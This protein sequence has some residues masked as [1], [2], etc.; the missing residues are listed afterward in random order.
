MFS[1]L[2]SFV[3]EYLK[4]KSAWNPMAVPAVTYHVAIPFCSAAD[5]LPGAEVEGGWDQTAPAAGG[6]PGQGQVPALTTRDIFTTVSRPCWRR[7]GGHRCGENFLK[8]LF[9]AMGNCM[10]SEKTFCSFTAVGNCIY[11]IQCNNS[12]NVQI[13]YTGPQQSSRSQ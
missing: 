8:L 12:C 13:T 1:L 6:G 7:W 5:Q 11:C 9:R 2:D 4:G 10:R 3:N